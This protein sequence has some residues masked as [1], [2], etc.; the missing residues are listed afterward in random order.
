MSL[1][2]FAT[3][4]P[5][6][7]STRQTTRNR[8]KRNFAIPAAAEAIPVNPKSAATSAITRKITAQ[9]N[10]I[11]PL[12]F[13]FAHHRDVARTLWRGELLRARSEP[14]GR[15]Q[16]RRSCALHLGQREL[17]AGDFPNQFRPAKNEAGIN[18]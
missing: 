7:K 13:C 2:P 14:D 17:E 10:I 3:L 6:I 12:L 18:L 11:I 4:I 15:F 1:E 5:A 8:K 9:R 16:R